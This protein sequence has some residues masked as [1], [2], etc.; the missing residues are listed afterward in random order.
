MRK[1]SRRRNGMRPEYK[2]SDFGTLV[3]GK[4]EGRASQASN[5]VV[6][7]PGL[8]NTTIALIIGLSE[9]SSLDEIT[10]NLL[11]VSLID[12]KRNYAGFYANIQERS[13]FNG[14]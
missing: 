10:V 5:V 9:T 1:A 8:V 4:Y 2:R 12:I 6:L 7:E 13:D 11:I 3:R 14:V